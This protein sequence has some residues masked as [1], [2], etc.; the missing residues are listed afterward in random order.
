[1]TWL[2]DLFMDEAKTA[3]EKYCDCQGD[4]DESVEVI[5]TDDANGN[6]TITRKEVG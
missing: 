2:K 3:L 1:M 5:V 6:V 4:R